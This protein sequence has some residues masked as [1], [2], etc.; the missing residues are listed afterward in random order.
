MNFMQAWESAKA[1]GDELARAIKQ[2]EVP[3]ARAVLSLLATDT[4]IP[5]PL[6]LAFARIAS[7]GTAAGSAPSEALVTMA[8]QALSQWMVAVRNNELPANSTAT[9]YARQ[10]AAWL[11]A[12]AQEDEARRR[13]AE[14][15][16][17]LTVP[18][19][20]WLSRTLIDSHVTMPGNQE[21]DVE[22][23]TKDGRG[24]VK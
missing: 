7:V 22:T 17:Q 24:V 5:K 2:R 13:A 19:V 3:P 8:F 12:H 9:T 11:A 14:W 15:V 10:L 23:A 18:A 1:A 20:E 6:L 4:A 21:R 16:T